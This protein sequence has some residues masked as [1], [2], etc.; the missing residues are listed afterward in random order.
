[1][2]DVIR[3]APRRRSGTRWWRSCRRVVPSQ[4]NGITGSLWR[5]WGDVDVRVHP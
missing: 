2:L 5:W 3:K 1:M 4:V